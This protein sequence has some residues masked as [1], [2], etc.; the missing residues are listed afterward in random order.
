MAGLKQYVFLYY[1]EAQR[2]CKNAGIINR[3]QYRAF[4]KDSKQIHSLPA[5]PSECIQWKND[6]KGWN[7]FLRNKSLIPK[8]AILIA[9]HYY[10]YKS[11]VWHHTSLG[12]IQ[13]EHRKMSN[14]KHYTEI[15]LEDGVRKNIR[16]N[17]VHISKIKTI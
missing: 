11:R 5:N 4:R 16:I 13:I 15:R 17:K 14:G 6:W 1:R 12:F 10:T 8:G 7:E 9:N 3:E 2:I